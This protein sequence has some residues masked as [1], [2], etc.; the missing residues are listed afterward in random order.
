VT[1]SSEPGWG[2]EISPEWLARS[3]YQKSEIA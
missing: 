1:I 2:I 3:A